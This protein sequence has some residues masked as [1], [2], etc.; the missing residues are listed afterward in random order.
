MITCWHSY[1]LGDLRQCYTLRQ[2]LAHATS[3]L[4]MVQGHTNKNTTVEQ[5]L[6]RRA[7]WVSHVVNQWLSM[8]TGDQITFGS[9]DGHPLPKLEDCQLHAIDCRILQPPIVDAAPTVESAFQIAVF[10]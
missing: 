4:A 10:S 6:V 3:A 1:L 9:I 8:C 5:E 7:I 2:Q